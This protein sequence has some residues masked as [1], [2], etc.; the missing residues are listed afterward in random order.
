MGTTNA[1]MMVQGIAW[2]TF[3]LAVLVA[4]LLILRVLRHQ[5]CF[6]YCDGIEGN[7]QTCKQKAKASAEEMASVGV[8]PMTLLLLCLW[9]PISMQ[10][11]IVDPCWGCYDFEAAAV[12]EI[13]HILGLNHPDAMGTVT[14]STGELF[15]VGSNSYMAMITSD[16]VRRAAPP[17]TQPARSARLRP[18]RRP[19]L[20]S[21]HP[22]V[23]PAEG[24]AAGGVGRA[25]LGSDERPD[26]RPSRV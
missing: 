23:R 5:H 26:R 25:G 8:L 20:P 1:L 21:G 12:H 2:G 15:P 19:D 16:D 18:D 4:A 7:E 17:R 9:T 14:K 13:G 10:N 22:A 6:D 24:Q 11:N 3:S